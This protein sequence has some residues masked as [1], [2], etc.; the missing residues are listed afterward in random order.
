MRAAHSS[1]SAFDFTWIIQN[2]ASSSFVSAKGP[3]V[4]RRL[5]PVNVTRVPF[6]LG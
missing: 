4:M 3:S 1:A 2:P 5:P 6:E